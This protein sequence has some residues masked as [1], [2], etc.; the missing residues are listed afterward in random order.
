MIPSSVSNSWKPYYD[1]EEQ[2]NKETL[3]RKSDRMLNVKS[4]SKYLHLNFINALFQ[5]EPEI[6][7]EESFLYEKLYSFIVKSVLR[8]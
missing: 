6:V 2:D 5:V 7:T 1:K 8:F 4:Q 3:Y